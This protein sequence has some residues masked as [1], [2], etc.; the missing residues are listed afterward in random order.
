MD[1]LTIATHNHKMEL[2]MNRVRECKASKQTVAKWCA[3]NGINSKTY[4][5]WMRKLKKEAFD[6][7]PINQNP[8]T[9]SFCTDSS[10]AE[11]PIPETKRTDSYAIRIQ[12]SDLFL[13]YQMVRM[14]QQ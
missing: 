5:Y 2:W 12:V 6:S 4:Y 14:A 10:F 8:G 7:L 1:Q 9:T 11:I 3:S 13:K